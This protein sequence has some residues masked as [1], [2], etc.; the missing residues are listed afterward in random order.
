MLKKIYKSKELYALIITKDYTD[1]GIHF[2]TPEEMSQ[3]VAYI[4]HIKGKI[5]EP[6][7]HNPV[8]REVI[9]TQE[10]LFIKKAVLL[11][12]V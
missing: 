12:I 1:D 7:F 4:R 2:F 8:P 6:H 11:K 5:I 9:Y 10:V 3:Q